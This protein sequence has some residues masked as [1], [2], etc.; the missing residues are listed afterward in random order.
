VK[1]AFVT[2]P[3]YMTDKLQLIMSSFMSLQLMMLIRIPKA[4]LRF[5]KSNSFH[6]TCS[7]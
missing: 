4:I 1:E 2:G 5:D 6:F 7:N 3:C